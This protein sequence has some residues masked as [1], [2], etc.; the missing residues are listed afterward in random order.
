MKANELRIGNWVYDSFND[1][2]YPVPLK[3]IQEAEEQLKPIAIT[4]NWLKKFGFH[5]HETK[6]GIGFWH[7]VE[8]D[9]VTIYFVDRG[10]YIVYPTKGKRCE[11]KY[12][13]Q[14]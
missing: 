13:H 10:D 9:F 2:E 3:M 1:E 4:E 7:W 8:D 11:I 5:L 14:L 6:D 12:V